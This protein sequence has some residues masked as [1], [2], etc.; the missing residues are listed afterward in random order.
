MRDNR[1]G[2]GARQSGEPVVEVVALD[3]PARRFRAMAA[4]K[5]GGVVAQVA[6]PVLHVT[7]K[8]SVAHDRAVDRPAHAQATVDV[9][10]HA[11]RAH[12]AA[13]TMGEAVDHMAERLRARLVDRATH[14]RA[15]RRSPTPRP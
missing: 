1:R 2:S 3:P 12:A 10:G 11:V 5:V 13:P 6:E 9:N 8:L 4:A 15:R 14:R 7:V